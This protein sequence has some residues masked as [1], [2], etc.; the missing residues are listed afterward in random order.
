M[1]GGTWDDLATRLGVG[2][3]LAAVG[4]AAIW[5]GGLWFHLFVA[6]AAGAM[7]W[8]LAR[9]LSPLQGPLAL[10]LGGLAGVALLLASLVPLWLA[11]PLLLAAAAVGYNWLG[12][13]RRAYA[14]FA[15]ATLIAAYSLV[16]WRDDFGL[17]WMLWLALVVIVTDVMGYFAGRFLGGPKFWPRVSPK[18]T[19]SGTAAGWLGAAI[20]GLI[21]VPLTGAGFGLIWMSVILSMASQAGDIAESALKRRCGVK[22]SSALLPGHGGV[23]DRFDGILGAALI[24]LAA[25]LIYGFPPVAM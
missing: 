25:R 24:L 4:I 8:E 13:G 11:L 16:L 5:A 3:L 10:Q 14:G 6:I 19:W 1:S 2:L 7:S 12:Q 21:F 15:T 23:L 17:L 9:M 18:K 20:L 22:D